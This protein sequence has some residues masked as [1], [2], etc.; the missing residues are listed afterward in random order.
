VN[1]IKAIPTASQPPS[2]DTG[3]TSLEGKVLILGN[4]I[5][6]LF[7]SGASY[8]FISLNIVKTLNLKD[9]NI[10]NP[11]VVYNLIGGISYLNLICKDLVLDI[12]DVD[13][14]CNAY[15][16]GF[17]GYR[18]NLRMDWLSYYGAILD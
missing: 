8:T 10:I 15:V 2:R 17:K 11:L 9:G 4:E 7:D 5:S 3:R 1:A 16:L 13:F 18:L 14:I 12:Y 6:T